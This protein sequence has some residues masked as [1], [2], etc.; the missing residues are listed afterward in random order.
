MEQLASTQET[1]FILDTLCE[2]YKADLV[3]LNGI[4]NSKGK[5]RNGQARPSFL[6]M[7][8]K[9]FDNIPAA[10][11]P[12]LYLALFDC[13]PNYVVEHADGLEYENGIGIKTLLNVQELL[14]N[15]IV[16]YQL[17]HS[18]KAPCPNSSEGPCSAK[19]NAKA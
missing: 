13:A 4:R 17:P 15:V 3:K 10:K 2:L 19:R 1:E 5:D 6:L 12:A 7:A 18:V 8:K 9:V 11:I 16:P 14:L